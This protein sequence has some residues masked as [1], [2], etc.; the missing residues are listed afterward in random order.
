MTLQAHQLHNR[1]GEP[2]IK[3]GGRAAG[4]ASS[5]G[6]RDCQLQT[7][8]KWQNMVRVRFLL[9]GSGRGHMRACLT[10]GTFFRNTGIA[11]L[12][13]SKSMAYTCMAARQQ[14]AWEPAHSHA[15]TAGL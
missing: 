12:A 11:S 15:K 14:C 10:P 3:T 5:R 4:R 9:D 1:R 7:A 6:R 8:T 13:V 2:T